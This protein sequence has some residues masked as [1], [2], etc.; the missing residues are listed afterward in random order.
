MVLTLD[1]DGSFNRHLFLC[2]EHR[3]FGETKFEN[4]YHRGRDIQREILWIMT[5][6]QDTLELMEVP[7]YSL[8]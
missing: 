3:S 5:K 1:K 2:P 6:L 4:R 7:K 8:R